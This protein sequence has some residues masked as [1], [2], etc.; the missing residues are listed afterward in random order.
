MKR[1]EVVVGQR[2]Q[3][4]GQLREPSA[5]RGGTVVVKVVGT[6][7][8]RRVDKRDLNTAPPGLLA[9]GIQVVRVADIAHEVPKTLCRGGS[10]PGGPGAG[11]SRAYDARR[12]RHPRPPGSCF[13]DI[14]DD[15]R[16]TDHVGSNAR[17]SFPSGPYPSH[18][19]DVG[20]D[21][22]V[23]RHACDDE[24]VADSFGGSP[25]RYG[26]GDVRVVAIPARLAGIAFEPLR[27]L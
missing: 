19:P 4:A 15:E 8:P 6:K 12:S 9:P 10:R 1:S 24:E 3:D 26:R 25:C 13:G 5:A 18:R 17:S 2:V 11:V 22:D 14:T 23:D 27:A 7:A 21:G 20:N 16:M